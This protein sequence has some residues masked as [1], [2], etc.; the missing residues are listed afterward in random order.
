LLELA[1]TGGDPVAERLLNRVVALNG[2]QRQAVDVQ[3]EFL[4]NFYK[5]R[6][7]IPREG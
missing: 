3:K 1:Q 4:S 5:L 7:D 6:D 2:D